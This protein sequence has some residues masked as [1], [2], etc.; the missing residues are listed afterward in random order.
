MGSVD[1]C[2][3]IHAIVPRHT[4]CVVKLI[5]AGLSARIDDWLKGGNKINII[6]VTKRLLS[7]ETEVRL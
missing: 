7:Q 6:D 1:M 3:F 5:R 4:E 2:H